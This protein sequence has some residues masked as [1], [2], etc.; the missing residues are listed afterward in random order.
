MTASS[1]QPEGAV[2]V[3][4]D[5]TTSGRALEAAVDEARR[6]QRPLHLVHATGPG[7]LPWTPERLAVQEEV[8]A[9]RHEQAL[10]LAPDLPVTSATHVDDAAAMLVRAS[11]T[12]SVVVVDAGSHGRVAGVMLGATAQKVAAHAACP[13]LVIPHSGAWARTGPVVVGLEATEHSR[14]AVGAA[15]AEAAARA[16][17]LVAVHSWWWEEPDPFLTGADWEGEWHDLAVTQE[18][19]VAEMLAGWKDRFPDVTVR[20]QVLRGQAVTLLRQYA[21]DAQLLVVGTRGVGGFR[22]LLLGSV[23]SSLL[24]SS[25]CPLLVVPHVRSPVTVA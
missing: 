14:P 6:L 11:G 24:H 21:A 9:Q 5:E 25:P 12:A 13:V 17:P 18:V 19:L 15:F 7:V 23:S 1:A 8:T 3:G 4:I 20:V 22:G 2:V 16:V 10:T